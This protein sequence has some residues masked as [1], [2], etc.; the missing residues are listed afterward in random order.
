MSGEDEVERVCD[1]DG[2]RGRTKGGGKTGA[3]IGGMR[4]NGRMGGREKQTRNK[5]TSSK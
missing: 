3:T 4:K 1:D 2:G 5:K